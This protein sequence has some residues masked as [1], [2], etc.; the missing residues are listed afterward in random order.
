MAV[1]MSV[2]LGIGALIWIAAVTTGQNAPQ[3][4]TRAAIAREARATKAQQLER[5][6]P[7]RAEAFLFYLEDRQLMARIFNPPRGWFARAGGLPQGAGLGVGPAWRLS[8]HTASLTLSS[9]ASMK[10]YWEVDS[11]LAFPTLAGGHAFVEIGGRRRSR[12]QE[13]FFGLGQTAPQGAQT[14]FALRETSVSASVG[15]TPVDWLRASGTVEY[16]TPRIGSGLDGRVPS[17]EERFTDADAP[18]L[19]AQ[20]DFLR[21]GARVT[22]DVSDRLLGPRS[23]GLY[24]LAFDQLSDRDLGRYSFS[25]WMVDL[26]QHVPVVA[27]ARTIVLRAHAVGQS[28]RAGHEVPFYLQP[29]IGGS[30]SVRGLLNYR[31]RDRYMLLLQAEYRYEL[32]AFMTGA[33]FYDAGRVASARRDLRL[34]GMRTS[35]GVGV[36]FGL[37]SNVSL[38]T[39]VAFGGAD[40]TRFLFKF[41]DVF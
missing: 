3:P 2:D 22:I 36:R 18:G 16:R 33:V 25:Q 29:T 5:S 13:D 4:E 21:T 35:W 7:D 23:G 30:N 37:L 41:N 38:R 34:R 8:N 32:N 10:G 31:L 12:P 26:Q 11:T 6:R 9:V 14:S 40:G 17:I 19:V 28:P 39:E 15:I 24:T 20:P 27:G 1:R